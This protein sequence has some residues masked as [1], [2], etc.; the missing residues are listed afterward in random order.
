MLGCGLNAAH[1]DPVASYW[2]GF[3]RSSTENTLS[4]SVTGDWTTY[5]G[6]VNEIDVTLSTD[7]ADVDLE[8]DGVPVQNVTIVE[9]SGG[10]SW[11]VSAA[12]I[13]VQIIDNQLVDPPTQIVTFIDGFG[14]PTKF[15]LADG[16]TFNITVCKCYGPHPAAGFV[17]TNAQCN[18]V[19]E[20]H[21][22]GNVGGAYCQYR[23]TED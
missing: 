20:C 14:T 1:A 17:C 9:E 5:T 3:D 22:T 16:A 10:T 18:Q 7:F 4:S 15:H 12:G 8:I 11:M 19:V 13:A 23:Y 6:T 21:S 2:A